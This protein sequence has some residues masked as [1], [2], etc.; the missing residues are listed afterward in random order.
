MVNSEKVYLPNSS[1]SFGFG[2]SE[3]AQLTAQGTVFFK[4]QDADGSVLVEWEKQNTLTHLA[5]LFAAW[6]FSGQNPPT[7]GVNALVM[8]TLGNLDL[9]VAEKK[10]KTF[11][12]PVAL[13]T[14]PTVSFVSSSDGR[15]TNQVD[16]RF[17][18]GP[19]NG[20][21]AALNEMGLAYLPTP[22]VNPDGY[23]FNRPVDSYE[24]LP[25]TPPPD[26][27]GKDVLIN[28]LPFGIIT[29]PEGSTLT[30]TWRLT[31]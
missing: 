10:K 14:A 7:T 22:P 2:F 30:V 4:L 23:V 21:R 15:P 6:L 8:G 24:P 18:F 9:S 3:P 19:G 5:P 13:A 1:F 11:I 12:T 26:I 29:K 28:Y 31:F 17:V 25:E 16:Y 20:D 27:R